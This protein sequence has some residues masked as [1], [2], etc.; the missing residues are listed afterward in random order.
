LNNALIGKA[1]FSPGSANDAE[2]MKSSGS[3]EDSNLLTAWNFMDYA[4]MSLKNMPLFS[5]S[6][7]SGTDVT[8]VDAFYKED[9]PFSRNSL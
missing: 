6:N 8:S 2:D 3:P 4:T 1:P 5:E 7:T 9:T